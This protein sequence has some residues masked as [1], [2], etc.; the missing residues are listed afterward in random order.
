MSLARHYLKTG[1]SIFQ[2]IFLSKTVLCWS[3]CSYGPLRIIAVIILSSFLKTSFSLGLSYR[4]G[5]NDKAFRNR[6]TFNRPPVMHLFTNEE[7][8]TALQV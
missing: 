3:L 4:F 1:R 5:I 8:A 2:H 7:V 6:L